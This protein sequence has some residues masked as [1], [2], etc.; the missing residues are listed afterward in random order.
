MVATQTLSTPS[1]GAIQASLVPSGEIF[2]ATR[3]GFPNSTVRG[4]S[5]LSAT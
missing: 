3:S 4:I 1:L 2:G 5:S